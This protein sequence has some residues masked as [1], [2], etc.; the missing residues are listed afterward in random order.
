[1]RSIIA[2]LIG[3][4]LIALPATGHASEVVIKLS[5]VVAENTPKG[6][7]ALRF[8]EIAE[9]RLPGRIKVE[10]YPHAV[11]MNDENVVEGLRQNTVQLA[12][13][14]LSLLEPYSLSYQVFDLPFLFKDTAAVA[15]FQSSPT[16]QDL[17]NGMHGAGIDGLCF[18]HNGMKQLSADVPLRLPKDAEGKK[19]RIQPSSVIAAQFEAAGAIPVKAPFTKVFHLLQTGTVDGQENTWSNIYSQRFYEVQPYITES[20]HASLEYMFIV[21]HDFWSTLPE[22]VRGELTKAV[23]DACEYGNAVAADLNITAKQDI[24][25]S[26][27]SKIIELTPEQRSQWV[28]AMK[29]VWTMFEGSIGRDVLDAAIAANGAG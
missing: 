17:L 14:S 8:K 28:D 16:G 4:A 27:F 13:P 9:Q 1:M 12:A 11:L 10:V 26:R 22:D 29:P 15:R 18:M 6:K 3:A 2:T 21:S 5:H 7:A 19:F 23:Q 24:I 25:K 20:N